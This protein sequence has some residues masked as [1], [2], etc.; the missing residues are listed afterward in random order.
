[1][2]PAA[3]LAAGSVICRQILKGARPDDLPIELAM[4]FDFV[5]NR[6]AA[7]QIGLTLPQALLLQANE[8]I[9]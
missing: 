7:R 8:L 2:V 6:S 5:M 1:M 3:P 9:E 4:H